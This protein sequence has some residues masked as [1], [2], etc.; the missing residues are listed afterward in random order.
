MLLFFA[1]CFAGFL[2]DFLSYQATEYLVDEPRIVAVRMDPIEPVSGAPFELD[3]LILAPQGWEEPVVEASLCGA[4]NETMTII[5]GLDCFEVE[6]EVTVLGAGELPLQLTAPTFPEIINCPWGDRAEEREED[7]EGES[8][9]EDE[10]EVQLSFTESSTSFELPTLTEEEREELLLDTGWKESE[11]CHHTLP[12]L[13]KASWGER[14]AEAFA[15]DFGE[16][17]PEAPELVTVPLHQH[18]MELTGPT[19]AQAGELVE[20]TFRVHADLRGAFFNWYID[21]GTLLGTGL[22]SVTSFEPPSE[23]KPI[24]VSTSSNIWRI[25]EE[26]SGPLRVWVVVHSL[27]TTNPNM[28]WRS[29]SVEVQP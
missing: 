25:P 17:F 1:G 10:D 21:A 13:L 28:A 12:T 8:Q 6:E 27:W 15:A 7:Q 18:P 16:W 19:E 14:E 26:A 24:A 2:T 22:T 29:M 9:E 20:L 5:W 23:S 11:P 3:A 4:G